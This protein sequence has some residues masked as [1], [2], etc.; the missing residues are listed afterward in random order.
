MTAA[1]FTLISLVLAQF[2]E[3][4]VVDFEFISKDGEV[5]DVVCLVARELRSG[6][7]LRLWHNQ[8]GSAPPYRTDSKVLFVCFAATAE[9][10]CH[11]ALNWPLPARILDLS[12]IFRCVVN[13][14]IVPLGKGLLGALA[15]FGLN[16]IGTTRKEMMRRRI[17]EGGPFSPEE[18]EEILI[19]CASDVDETIA[20][21]PKLLAEPDFD[22]GIALHWGEFAAVSALMEHRGIPLDMQIVPQLL[23][24]KAWAFVRDTVV[25]KIDQQYGVYIEDTVGEWHFNIEKFELLCVRLGIDWPRHEFGKP[26]LRRK[27]FE[28]MCK[29]YPE[30]EALRQLRHARD[31]MR[32]IKLAVGP[33]GRNRTVLWPFASKT[34]RTQPKAAQWIFSPATW[35]RSSIKPGPGRAIAYI[36]WSSM[37][38]QVAAVLSKCRPMLELYATG[39]PYIEFAKRFDVVPQSATKKTNRKCTIPTKL[40]CSARN[41]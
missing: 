3:I 6:R 18:R 11:L 30:L 2:E 19:Y 28:S 38:F 5:P 34:S 40:C 10:A 36:D 7:T 35:L 9:C 1:D 33:D 32:R 14:R 41:T 29:A 25:P 17:L 26:D 4:W 15:Y 20:L 37:E 31:K 8:L 22:L 21:L 12:P 16:S 39:S 27:T 23:D 24:K 13:G